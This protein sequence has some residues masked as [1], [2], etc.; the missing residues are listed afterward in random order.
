MLPGEWHVQSPAVAY[1]IL[2]WASST[3][4]LHPRVNPATSRSFNMNIHK[5]CGMCED[6]MVF[7]ESMI[8]LY[9][10]DTQSSTDSNSISV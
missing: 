4:A 10:H 2:E 7:T 1:V 8:V 3:W 6:L 9:Y 5:L